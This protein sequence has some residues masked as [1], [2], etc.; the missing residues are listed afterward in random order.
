M[1][2]WSHA[3]ESLKTLSNKY[4][5]P[6]NF[7]TI[8]RVNRLISAWP[9]D[10]MLPAEGLDGV[11]SIYKKLQPGLEDVRNAAEEEAR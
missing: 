9:M 6:L 7:E 11:K 10:D 2:C 1:E 8:G 4:S 3:A 5:S